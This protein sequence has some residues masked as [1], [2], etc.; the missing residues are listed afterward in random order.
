MVELNARTAED[1]PE[2]PSYLVDE[3]GEFVVD[4]ASPDD[5]AALVAHLFRV[6]DEA[7]RADW[8]WSADGQLSDAGDEHDE[9]DVFAREAGFMDVRTR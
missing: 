1:D 4:P 6:S 5:R 9:S 7:R 8:R 3:E 2:V